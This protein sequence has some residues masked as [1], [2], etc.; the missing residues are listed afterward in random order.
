MKV[1]QD[2]ILNTYPT[3]LEEVVPAKTYCAVNWANIKE[4]YYSN[5]FTSKY[6]QDVDQCEDILS[7]SI[8]VHLWEN[9]T[10]NKYKIDFSKVHKDSL[11][12]KLNNLV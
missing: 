3:W 4:L 10:L 7:S 12:R 9:L 11:Y 2:A 8:G 1:F 5:R 6:G